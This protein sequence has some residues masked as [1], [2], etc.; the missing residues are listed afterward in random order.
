MNEATGKT[1][2]ERTEVGLTGCARCIE[3]AP[4][5]IDYPNAAA[6]GNDR[7][8]SRRLSQRHLVAQMFCGGDFGQPDEAW[9]KKKQ[10]CVA[11]N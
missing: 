6:R 8:K 2:K 7:R 9:R 11:I 3:E 5:P 1:V 10:G 4:K